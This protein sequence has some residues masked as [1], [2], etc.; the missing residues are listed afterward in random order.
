MRRLDGLVEKTI[1]EYAYEDATCGDE[2]LDNLYALN[3]TVKTITKALPLSISIDNYIETQKGLWTIEFCGKLAIVRT[4]IATERKYALFIPSNEELSWINFEKTDTLIHRSWYPLFFQKITEG[5]RVNEL[6][7]R[8]DNVSF[9]I[10]NCDRSFKYFMYNALMVYYNIGSDNAIN[11]V[12]N[13]HINHP[14]GI[15]GDLWDDKGKCTFGIL[16]NTTQM[17][18]LT[19]RIKTFTES[20]EREKEMKNSVQYLVE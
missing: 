2:R 18:Q 17:I 7:K 13:L 12:R 6:S 11:I 9:I 8:L 16:P 19:K 3:D 14:Y 20:R 4:I 15:I 1:N 10:F 5:C